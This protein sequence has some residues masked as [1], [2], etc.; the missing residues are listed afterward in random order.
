VPVEIAAS[1]V[2]LG[3]PEILFRLDD[4]VMAWDTT[5]DHRRFLLADRPTR[6][7]DPIYVILNWDAG[8]AAETD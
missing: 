1:T 8:I 7:N 3:R 2:R 6:G 4:G 5:G